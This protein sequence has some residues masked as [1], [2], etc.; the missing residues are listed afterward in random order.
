MDINDI[1]CCD[2]GY[3]LSDICEEL[4]REIERITIKER[5]IISKIQQIQRSMLSV[6]EQDDQIQLRLL[7]KRLELYCTWQRELTEQKNDI[8]FGLI[9]KIHKQSEG[10]IAVSE[11]SNSIVRQYPAKTT[12]YKTTKHKIGLKNFYTKRRRK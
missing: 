10:D 1:G 12:A 8:L 7:C 3:D 9:R 6:L 4:K 2:L 11:I 5:K